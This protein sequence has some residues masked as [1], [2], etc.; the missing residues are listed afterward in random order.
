M[1]FCGGREVPGRPGLQVSGALSVLGADYDWTTLLACTVPTTVSAVTCGRRRPGQPVRL[2]PVCPR[3][4]PW[5]WRK[6]NLSAEGTAVL[7]SMHW[8]GF[9]GDGDCLK[10]AL[11]DLV[12]GSK[13]AEVS[14]QTGAEYGEPGS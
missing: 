11:R 1:Y 9:D 8:Q 6:K 2:L 10:K 14:A 3:R 4:V 5:R 13:D 7:E 12:A